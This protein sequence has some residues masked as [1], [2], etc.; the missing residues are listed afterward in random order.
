MTVAAWWTLALAAF[1]CAATGAD[2]VPFET[3][4]RGPLSG[5]ETARDSVARTDAEWTALWKA[6][7][8]DTPKPRVDMA[9]RTVVGVFL[10]SRPSGGYAAEI[11]RIERQAGELV[12]TWREK[13]PGPDE[14]ASAVLTQPFHIVS[15]ERV[16][17][18]IRFARER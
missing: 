7:A 3:V 14:M 13:R 4:A 6:H 16:T 18:P 9:A 11:V 8:A 15:I 12:V 17:G 1:C 5:I 10:G 2:T